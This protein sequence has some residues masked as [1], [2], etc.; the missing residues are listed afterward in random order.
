MQMESQATFRSLQNISG[1]SRQNTVTAFFYTTE[2][3]GGSF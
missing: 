2:V 1:A 3:E